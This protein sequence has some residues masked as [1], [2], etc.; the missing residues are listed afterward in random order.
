M[1]IRTKFLGPTDTRGS[2]VKA[3]SAGGKSLTKDWNYELSSDA[4]HA[5]AATLLA[6][7]LT[8]VG[9]SSP[10]KW[11]RR[12]DKDGTCIHVGLYEAELNK[13]EGQ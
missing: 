8:E 9:S 5:M 3:T 12:W 1:L 13:E 6:N 11:I 2:R 4:N 10:V 7:K